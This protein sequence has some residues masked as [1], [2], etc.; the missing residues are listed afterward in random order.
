MVLT[1]FSPHF[2]RDLRV[3]KLLIL[4]TYHQFAGRVWLTYDQAFINMQLYNFHA[5]GASARSSSETECPQSTEGVG[6]S[7]AMIVCK[8]W[9][10]GKCSPT[11]C[12]STLIVVVT[13]Q[14]TT[15]PPCVRVLLGLSFLPAHLLPLVIRSNFSGTNEPCYRVY[16]ILWTSVVLF[17]FT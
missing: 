6:S 1:S 14:A 12:A 2:W 11:L 8:T 5:A 3:Y 7:A 10:W 13:V 15:G 17:I 4:C 16:V 9:N